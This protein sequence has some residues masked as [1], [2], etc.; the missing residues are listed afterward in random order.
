MVLRAGAVLLLLSGARGRRLCAPRADEEV[1]EGVEPADAL[2]AASPR[3]AGAARERLSLC[4]DGAEL[5]DVEADVAPT[6]AARAEGARGS[7][8]APPGASDGWRAAALLLMLLGTA[9]SERR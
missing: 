6:E 4:T 9:E 3:A 8:D 2:A 7:G 5:Q 1:W